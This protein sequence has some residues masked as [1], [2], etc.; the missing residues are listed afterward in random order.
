MKKS[1]VNS[2][3]KGKMEKLRQ[4]QKIFLDTITSHSSHKIVQLDYSSKAGEDPT[5][6]QM[7]MGL[8]SRVSGPLHRYGLETRGICISMFIH[9]G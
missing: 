4:L 6:Q 3:E 8:K 1:G 2:I 5:L 7:I 9:H